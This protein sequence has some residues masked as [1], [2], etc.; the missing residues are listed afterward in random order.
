[1]K[2]HQFGNHPC[3]LIIKQVF[4]FLFTNYSHYH[5]YR[6]FMVIVHNMFLPVSNYFVLIQADN[7]L[8]SGD[9]LIKQNIDFDEYVF[10]KTIMLQT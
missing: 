10:F 3:Q 1:M 4:A 2:S 8:F 5:C 6:C 7:Q 9:I